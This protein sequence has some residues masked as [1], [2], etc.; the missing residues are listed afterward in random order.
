MY[1]LFAVVNNTKKVKVIVNKL[2]DIGI[3]GATIFDTMGSHAF[4]NEYIAKKGSIVYSMRS[5]ENPA[6]FNKTLISIIQCE[7]HVFEAI[8]AIEE[9][10]GGDLTKPG[11]GIVFTVPLINYQGGALGECIENEGLETKFI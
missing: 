1:A 10:L 7:K 4:Y 8:D 6:I 5:I 3:K 11:T 9:I 2:K